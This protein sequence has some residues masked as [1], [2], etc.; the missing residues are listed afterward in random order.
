M[1]VHVFDV[2]SVFQFVCGDWIC[3]FTNVLFQPPLCIGAVLFQESRDGD[4]TVVVVSVVVS[5]GV[6]VGGVGVGVVVIGSHVEVVVVHGGG[7]I[8]VLHNRL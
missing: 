6:V 5:V 4:W 8:I 7:F 3:Q 1:D 2:G